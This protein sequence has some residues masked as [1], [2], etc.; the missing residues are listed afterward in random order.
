MFATVVGQLI[1]AFGFVS[2]DFVALLGILLNGFGIVG[3]FFASLL[4]RGAGV[5]RFKIGSLVVNG[6]TL[7]AFAYFAVSAKVLGNQT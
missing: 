2:S 7:L 4:F 5:R 1:A 6:L 3:A